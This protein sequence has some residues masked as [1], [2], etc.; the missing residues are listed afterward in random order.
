MNTIKKR[1]QKQIKQIK[2]GTDDKTT[3]TSSLIVD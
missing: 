3:R 2:G 1:K